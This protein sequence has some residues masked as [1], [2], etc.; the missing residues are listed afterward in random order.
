MKHL[1]HNAFR[2]LNLLD[3]VQKSEFYHDWYRL[4]M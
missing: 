1:V 4:V 3:I 2:D